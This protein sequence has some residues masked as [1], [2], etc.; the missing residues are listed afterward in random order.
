MKF[1]QLTAASSDH[2]TVHVAVDQV[3]YIRKKFRGQC[4]E[5]CFADE[6]VRVE[7]SPE[8]I[9]ALIRESE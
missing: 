5:V 3:C 8:Q 1:I 7:E 2:T 4:S 6:T 9:M